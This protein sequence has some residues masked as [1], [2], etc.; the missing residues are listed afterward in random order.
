L[1]ENQFF[2]ILVKKQIPQK[3][4]FYSITLE[5]YHDHEDFLTNR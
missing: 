2:K 4:V 3:K 1:D 5:N